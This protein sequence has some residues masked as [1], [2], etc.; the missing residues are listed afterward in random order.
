M[1]FSVNKAQKHTEKQFRNNTFYAKQHILHSK[2][3]R[4]TNKIKL[5]KTSA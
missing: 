4:H 1:S 3:Q 5:S 2:R